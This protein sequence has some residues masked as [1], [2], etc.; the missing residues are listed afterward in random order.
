MPNL[1]LVQLSA[2]E[3]SCFC[4]VLQLYLLVLWKQECPNIEEQPTNQ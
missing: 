1:H 4:P 3:L 2:A